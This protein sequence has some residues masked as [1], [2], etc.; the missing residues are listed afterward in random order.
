MEFQTVLLRVLFPCGKGRIRDM[1]W[2]LFWTILLQVII[3][4]F[5]FYFV[6]GFIGRGIKLLLGRK[7]TDTLIFRGKSDD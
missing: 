5:T 3:G 2:P 4:T 7:K 6:S 1:D